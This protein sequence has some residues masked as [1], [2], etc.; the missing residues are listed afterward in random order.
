MFGSLS[1]PTCVPPY[2]IV[3]YA[4]HHMLNDHLFQKIKLIERYKFNYLIII[5][6]FSLTCRLKLSFNKVYSTRE[7]FNLIGG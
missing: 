2:L 6:T 1:L 7:I 5:L 3:E 4:L